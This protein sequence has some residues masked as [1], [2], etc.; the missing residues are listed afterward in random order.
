MTGPADDATAP[1]HVIVIDDNVVNLEIFELTLEII[2][3]EVTTFESGEQA[4][5]HL[6]SIDSAPDLLIID[7][8]MPGMDG[9]ELVKA[10]RSKPELAG[11]RIL[12]ASAAGAQADIDSGIAAGVDAYVSKPFSPQELLDAISRL[13]DTPGSAS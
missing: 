12:M 10:V 13:L 5:T 11:V 6:G 1:L 9:I 2:S 3:A 4:M 8:L 7:R